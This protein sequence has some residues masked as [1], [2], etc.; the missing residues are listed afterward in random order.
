MFW[1]V[2]AIIL[3]VVALIVGAAAFFAAE[4]AQRAGAAVIAVVVALVGFGLFAVGG[5]KSV[6]VKNIGVPTSFGRVGATAYQP[7]IHETWTPWLHLTDINETVQTTTWEGG[8]CLTVRI[9]GQQSACA[10]VTIQWQV[11]PSAAGRLFSD[12]ANNT[13]FM[14]EITN[15][16]VEREFKTVVN[17]VLGDYNPITDVQSVANSSAQTSQ[18]TTYGPQ[19]LKDMQSDIGSE[20]TVRSVYLPQLHFSLAIEAELQKIQTAYADQAVAQENV[21]VDQSNSQAYA[22]LGNPSQAALEAQCLNDVKS[23]TNLP[24]G[25]S[26]FPG[27]GSSLALSGK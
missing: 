25:F 7:G 18:F 15:A 10:D 16:V 4:K 19:I 26:C 13:D 5:L 6:P 8:N 24:A 1:F 22:K 23:E 2:L 20:I 17:N 9:G 14:S 27:S 11:K 3:W 12:Y 21:K